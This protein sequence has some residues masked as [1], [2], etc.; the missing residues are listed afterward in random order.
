MKKNII[1]SSLCFFSST[2]LCDLF[3]VSCAN[4]DVIYKSWD[5]SNWKGIIFGK[6]NKSDIM[7][8][9]QNFIIIYLNGSNI[10]SLNLIIP[11][12][13][14]YNGVI[15]MVKLGPN[16]FKDNLNIVGTVELNKF[17]NC[18]P[19]ACFEG[20]AS[21]TDVILNVYPIEFE[22]F[23]FHN[24]Y[25]LEHI[26]VHHGNYLSDKW[27]LKIEKIGDSAFY[28]AILGGKLV[29]PKSLTFL[30]DLAFAKCSL[31]QSVNLSLCSE[32]SELN[33]GVF[34]W[35]S[36]LE[37][38]SLPPNI[39][40]IGDYAFLWCDYLKDVIFYNK[41]TI[42]LGSSTF[43]GCSSIHNFTNSCQFGNIGTKC[44]V[45]A[46]KLNFFPWDVH[47]EEQ[48]LQKTIIYS[49]AFESC[50]FTYLSFDPAKISDVKSYAFS[51]NLYL[52]VIDFSKY[53]DGPPNW[54]GKNI[55][56]KSPEKGLVILPINQGPIINKKWKTFLT[57]ND[58]VTDSE[59]WKINF[60]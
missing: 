9:E 31:I 54:L 8:D 18:I 16:C 13:V 59:H 37:K 22:D 11:N 3:I 44:F 27:T 42:E 33:K 29:F 26:W 45:G 2:A 50:N 53:V 49:Q 5:G 35:C 39:T 10:A 48:P 28:G 57:K 21:I 7:I 32:I 1:F 38:V 36:M 14:N 34:A 60:H 6:F 46:K 55:F 56:M 15:Y 24:C 12:Y 20:C 4:E 58:I 41:K 30:G 47:Q 52:S 43:F 17:T 23:A 25:S 19:E 40:K 51:N